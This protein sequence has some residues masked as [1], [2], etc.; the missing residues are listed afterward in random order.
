[1]SQPPLRQAVHLVVDE[2]GAAPA[3]AGVVTGLSPYSHLPAMPV[4]P[5]AVGPELLL[6]L[7]G[8]VLMLAA[9]WRCRERDIG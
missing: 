5:F 1:V 6:S 2:A 3:L 8:A 7:L 4:E 9:W